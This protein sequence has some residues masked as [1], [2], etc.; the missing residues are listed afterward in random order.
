MTRLIV[1]PDTP[2]SPD[3]NPMIVRSLE[4]AVRRLPDHPDASV[5]EL[6]FDHQRT[7][8][9]TLE[10]GRNLVIEAGRG[11]HPIV[12][13][14]AEAAGD[15]RMLHLLGGRLT[16]RRVHFEVDV[17][18]V[19]EGG[20]AM[21]HLNEVRQIELSESSLTMRNDSHAVAAFF[22]VQGPR[23]SDPRA[24]LTMRCPIQFGQSSK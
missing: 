6:R 19:S 18:P 22:Q 13:F 11:Y 24:R 12:T 4:E 8:P 23:M 20:W 15:K 1:M 5:I 17:P 14:E 21:F 3:P 10:L 2:P 16:L 7:R 9:L